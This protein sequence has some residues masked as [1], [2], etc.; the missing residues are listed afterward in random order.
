V[1]LRIE[2][3][4]TH[5][6]PCRGT[7][8]IGADGLGPRAGAADVLTVA[9]TSYDVPAGRRQIVKL[10]LTRAELRRLQRL[11]TAS[12]WAVTR[13]QADPASRV[14]ARLSTFGLQAPPV[15]PRKGER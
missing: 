10:R 15:K 11:E 4:R 6:G 1:P 13:E 8:A 3:P 9:E 5:D 14:A 7:L 2:C 12:A